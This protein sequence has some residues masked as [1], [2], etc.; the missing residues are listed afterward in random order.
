M[1]RP[2]FNNDSIYHI[3]NRGVE[4]RETFLA[5][6][7]YLRFVLGLY[8]F[9]SGRPA[10][11]FGYQL[12]RQSIEVRLQYPRK[13]LFVDILVFC[14]MPNHYHLMI[15]QLRKGGITEFMRKLGT[16]YTN[17][18]NLKYDRVGPLFQGK[19]KA[20][21]LER[22]AHFMHLPHYI[23]CNPLELIMPTWREKIM[24]PPQV[25]KALKLL[26]GYRW[27]SYPDYIGKKNFPTVTARGFLAE[28]IGKPPEFLRSTRKWL[29]DMSFEFIERLTHE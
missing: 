16:G 12:N 2:Q 25:Q 7:D 8:E 20:L 13:D 6:A 19:F 17:Y 22:E 26:T 24:T 9:N 27:S 29:K 14:L 28:C 5:A 3:Y 1:Q 10:L 21:S 18:F 4:K 11:N 15:K 23:H